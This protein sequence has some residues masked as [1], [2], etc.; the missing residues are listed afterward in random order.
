MII[1]TQRRYVYDETYKEVMQWAKRMHE[2]KQ[3]YKHP[4]TLRSFSFYLKE[5]LKHLKHIPI[6][7]ESNIATCSNTESKC[8]P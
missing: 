1:K 8:A 2:S 6:N 5:Y 4:K 7:T 3:I